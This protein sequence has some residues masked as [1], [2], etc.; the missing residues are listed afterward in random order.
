[1]SVFV[2]AEVG[3]A[4]DGSLGILHSYIDAVATTGADA[5]KFQTHIPEAESSKYEP[6]RVNFSYEDETRYDYWKRMSFTLEQW[7]GIKFH[8]EDVG[9]EFMSSPFSL[10]AVELL[11]D[12]GVNKYKIGSGEVT[13]NLL[14]NAVCNT[15]K[16]IIISSGMS[17]FEELDHAV[18]LIN[19]HGN[20]LSILQCT[21]KYPT[22]PEDIGLNALS[23]LYG[24]YTIPVGLSDHSGTIYPSIAAVAL[25]ATVIEAHIVFDKLMFGPDTSSSLTVRQFKEMVGGVR[26][27]KKM[28]NSPIDK[29]SCSH[30]S[31]L[32]NMFE[33]SLSV[34]KTL[35]KGT[36]ITLLDLESKKPF[37]RGI[38]AK[39]YE[40]VIGRVLNK[41]L[42]KWDFI[43]ESDIDEKD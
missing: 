15:G 6:F 2:I 18:G 29:E 25:G 40:N 3:Q 20:K 37:G 12:L 27:V 33:K 7:K 4:H 32:K 22:A 11:E 28:L 16:E 19:Q 38:P 8:C 23:E 26:A 36:K 10:A 14:L 39:N 21:T 1:M 24:R 35:K 9:L 31:D 41:D 5:I 34:N 42:N 30:F 13:N 17:S 43:T